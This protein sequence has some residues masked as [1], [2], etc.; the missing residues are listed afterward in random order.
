MKGPATWQNEMRTCN[1]C[2]TE[3]RPKRFWQKQCKQACRQ[4]VY[5]NRQALGTPGYYGA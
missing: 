3:F 2:K 4:R 1:G 5:R